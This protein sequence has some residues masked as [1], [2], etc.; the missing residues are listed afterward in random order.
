MSD[1]VPSD[2]QAVLSQLLEE[3]ETAI[4]AEEFD[5]ARQTIQ[6]ATT[7]SQNKLSEGDLREQLL[8]GCGEVLAAIAVENGVDSDVAVAYVRAMARRLPQ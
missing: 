5:T 4:R 3:T 2:V 7:V 1:D 8:H 6:T